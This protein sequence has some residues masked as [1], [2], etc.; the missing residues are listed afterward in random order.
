MV[1]AALML[2]AAPDAPAVELIDFRLPP[3]QPGDL[4]GRRCRAST[5]DEIIV[6][7]RRQGGF[8]IPP[9]SALGPD[10]GLLRSYEL[11]GGVT[12]TPEITQTHHTEGPFNG[13]VDRRVMFTIRF[14]F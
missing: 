13:M 7:G 12:L 8:R 9:R 4:L 1:L 11:G 2:V 6:C 3:A 5:E 14:P 10:R